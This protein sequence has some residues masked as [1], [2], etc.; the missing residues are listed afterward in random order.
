MKRWILLIA[1]SLA[2]VF[3]LAAVEA[4]PP[5]GAAGPP[6]GRVVRLSG[7]VTVKRGSAPAR[8]LKPADQFWAADLVAV[9]AGG[10]ATLHFYASRRRYRVSGRS[11]VLV[12]R[13]GL[14]PRS[15][16]APQALKPLPALLA[17]RG[18]ASGGGARSTFGGLVLRGGEGGVP[19]PVAPLGAVRVAGPVALAW[20]LPDGEAA[21]GR[22]RVRVRDARTLVVAFEA[23]DVPAGARSFTV[24]EG[25]LKAGKNLLWDVSVER[26]D[27]WLSSRQVPLRLLTPAD[28]A[29]A[30]RLHALAKTLGAQAPPDADAHLLLGEAYEGLGLLQEARAAYARALRAAPNAGAREALTRIARWLPADEE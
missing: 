24:P 27:E 20:E 6:A 22:L 12:T 1:P 7:A 30:A 21:D 5:A 10:E 29:R 4:P 17:P 13:A 9:P 3:V 14:T 16:P 26:D 28:R 18:A 8:A 2:L 11:M 23:A 19:R 15:G 25:A